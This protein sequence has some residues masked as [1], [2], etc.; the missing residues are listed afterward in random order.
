MRS[1][2][3]GD[4]ALASGRSQS[5]KETR[6]QVLT[7]VMCVL[8]EEVKLKKHRGLVPGCLALAGGWRPQHREQGLGDRTKSGGWRGVSPEWGLGSERLGSC[9]RASRPLPLQP[10]GEGPGWPT[11]WAQTGN[12]AGSPTRCLTGEKSVEVGVIFISKLPYLTK[13]FILEFL[14]SSLCQ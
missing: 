3:Q 8:N 2:A 7:G 9:R 1:E 14:N 4:P 12:V 11:A 13:D 10:P 5:Y 6:L